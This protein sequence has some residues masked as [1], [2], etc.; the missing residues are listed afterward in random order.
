MPIQAAPR[1][2][3]HPA[4]PFP[5]AP[6][7]PPASTLLNPVALPLDDGAVE[8]PR[9]RSRSPV[10]A[11]SIPVPA[12]DSMRLDLSAELSRIIEA[13]QQKMTDDVLKIREQQL[14]D[15]FQAEWTKMKGELTQ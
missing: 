3:E 15:E 14:T 13:S 11:T 8:A 7:Q 1:G 10:P 12:E 4:I 2:E 5:P 6:S 9:N